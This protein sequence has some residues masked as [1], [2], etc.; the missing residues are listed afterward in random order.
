MSKLS[1]EIILGVK[2]ALLDPIYRANLQTYG[3]IFY[4]VEDS[5]TD[6]NKI[7]TEHPLNVFTTVAAAYAACTTNRNDVILISANTGHTMSAV[8]DVTKSRVHFIGMTPVGINRRYGLRSRLT[9][10]VTTPTTD[11]AVVKNTGVGNSFRN[12][13]FDSSNTLTQS[14]YAFAE[15]GEYTYVEN[16]EFYK[17]THL[18]SSTAAELLMNGDSSHFKNCLFGSLV[19]TTVST[20]I[21][22]AVL[23]TRETITGKVCRDGFFEGCL[24]YTKAADVAQRLVYSAGAT[25]VERSLVFKDCIFAAAKLGAAVPAEAVGGA[26]ALTQGQI[27]LKDCMAANITKWSTL[28]GVVGNMPTADASMDTVAVQAA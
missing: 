26:A 16:C 12:L 20:A 22:P 17:S 27:I 10:G 19:N 4:V 21:R 14:L 5:D 24:F 28:T 9:M 7:T 3:E 23:L 13:K 1:D 25:D 18:N 15:G 11:I 2:D 6:F 8:L